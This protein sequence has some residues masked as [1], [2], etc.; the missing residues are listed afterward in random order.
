MNTA[1]KVILAGIAGLVIGFFV[2]KALLPQLGGDF[3]GG[4]VPGNVWV[5]SAATQSCT[6]VNGVPNLYLNGA[7]SVGGTAANNQI[8]VV[9]TATT[10]YPATAFN[11]G[12]I[13]GTTSTTSTSQ[14]FTAPGFSVG[15]ACEVS[16]NGASTTGAFGADAF[17]TAVSGNAVTTTATFWNGGS[18]A[19][20]MNVTSSATGAS[21]TLKVT[22]FHTGV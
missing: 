8:P 13:Q 12:P 18:S 14:S 20:T 5:C 11:L 19:I 9:Y 1:T 21:S 7:I 2:G 6:P 3:A 15:D 10:S 22:C 17:V 16:Y 4:I